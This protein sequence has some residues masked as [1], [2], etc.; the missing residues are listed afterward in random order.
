MRHNRCHLVIGVTLSKP[1][2]YQPRSFCKWQQ[3]QHLHYH[4][5]SFIEDSLEDE[6]SLTKCDNITQIYAWDR[7]RWTQND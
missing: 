7:D 1:T 3:Q 6:N 2:D 5:Y 4:G